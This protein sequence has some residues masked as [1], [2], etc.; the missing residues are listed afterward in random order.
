MVAGLVAD[1]A[2]IALAVLRA[3]PPR[4]V[5]VS[6][7]VAAFGYLL[8]RMRRLVIAPATTF[9]SAATSTALFLEG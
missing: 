7:G 2:A 6:D 4:L 5:V 3:P 1:V 9:A 8:L